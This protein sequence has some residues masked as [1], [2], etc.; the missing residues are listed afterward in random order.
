MAYAGHPML[1]TPNFDETALVDLRFDRF[2]AAALVCSPTHARV[3]TGRYLNRT[4]VFQWEHPIR[5]SET[6]IVESL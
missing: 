4:G 3:L 1:K 5:P 6:T 2:Q